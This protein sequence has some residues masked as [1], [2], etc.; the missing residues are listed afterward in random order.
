MMCVI[1]NENC[2]WFGCK[3]HHGHTGEDDEKG[4]GDDEGNNDDDEN[5]GKSKVAFY[6]NLSQFTFQNCT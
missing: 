4:D 1:C 2:K 3:D 6:P 5:T